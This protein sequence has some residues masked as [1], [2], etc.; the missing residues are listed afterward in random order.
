MVT[1]VNE[2]HR[3]AVDAV[4]EFFALE[5]LGTN[6]NGKKILE[7][8]VIHD[9]LNESDDGLWCRDEDGWHK[10]EGDGI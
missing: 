7:L 1:T 3:A 9:S 10:V 2:S 5:Y 8:R 6:A 4:G